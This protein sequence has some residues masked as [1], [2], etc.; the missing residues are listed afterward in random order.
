MKNK[1][2]FI[3]YK[4]QNY[5]IPILNIIGKQN[6]IE[7]TVA[8]SAKKFDDQKNHFKEITLEYKKIGPLTLYDRNFKN[9][10]NSFDVIVCMFY[11]QNLS[12]FR[13]ALL[14]KRKF[15]LI[16]WGIGVRASYDSSFDSPTI[17]NRLRNLWAKNSDA[18]IFYTEYAKNKYIKNGF[19][20]EKLFVMPNTVE[21]SDFTEDQGCRKDLLFIGSLYKSKK[22]FEL[23]E[24]YKLASA[25]TKKLPKLRIV[26]DGDEYENIQKWV[27]ATN[28]TENIILHGAIYDE[29]IL[30]KLF[31]SSIACISPGQ[32][33][34]SVLK[35]FGYGVPFITQQ[36][37]ITGGER[38]NIE[39]GFNGIL[40]KDDS[41]LT[42]I[43]VDISENRDKY[44][45]MGENA[46][47]FYNMERTPQHMAQG[48]IDA[49]NYTLNKR[50]LKET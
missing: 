31:T 37:A 24:A 25:N 12:F 1:V 35:S 19:S 14:N 49:L 36:N 8:H 42:K 28:N 50:V 29:T 30:A 39:H 41:E 20:E 40:Y 44:L 18:M 15:K 32:A 22:V 34:L 47:F 38:L 33:G 17:F 10:V 4:L 5:R 6:D 2:L 27:I 26:G 48:F 11:L 21:V 16:F 7:L 13:L 45:K 3:T 43:L 23:V 9:L 46:K